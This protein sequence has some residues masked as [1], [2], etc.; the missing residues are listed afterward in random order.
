VWNK[1][2]QDVA[3]KKGAP[4]TSKAKGAD[5]KKDKGDKKKLDKPF[6]GPGSYDSKSLFK[7]VEKGK[8][9]KPQTDKDKEKDGKKD[10]KAD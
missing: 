1:I 6:P 9:A 7:T 8:G 10:K 4:G 5:D 3:D 2:A